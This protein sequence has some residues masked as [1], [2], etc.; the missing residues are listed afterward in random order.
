MSKNSCNSGSS[1]LSGV[2]QAVAQQELQDVSKYC[3]KHGDAYYF[4]RRAPSPFKPGQTVHL[5][6]NEDVRVG[7]NGYFR[8][9]LGTSSAAD[10]KK[11]ARKYASLLDDA[12]DRRR[13]E[14][15]YFRM[16]RGEIFVSSREATDQE[17]AKAVERMHQALLGADE[18]TSAA[19]F[20]QAIEADGD[21][22]EMAEIRD[23]DRYAELEKLLPPDTSIGRAQLVRSMARI[24][25]MVGFYLHQVVPY[26]T[27]VCSDF[28]RLI[29]FADTYIRAIKDLER[30]REGKPVEAPLSLSSAIIEEA[31]IDGD[32]A[33]D[34]AFQAYVRVR[35]PSKKTFYSYHKAWETLR[36]S[37]KCSLKQL[38]LSHVVRWRDELLSGLNG[39]GLARSTINNHITHGRTIWQTARSNA[40]IPSHL[41]NPFDGTKLLKQRN[42]Q[43][44]REEFSLDELK[45]LFSV[46]PLET[47]E[48]ISVHSG[49]WLP[50]LAMYH[51]ARLEELTGLLVADIFE[52][53][54]VPVMCIFENDRRPSL[55]NSPSQ[56][57]IPLHPKLLDL[58]FLEYVETAR[59]ANVKA[60]FPSTQVGRKFGEHYVAWA[61]R[62]LNLPE[63]RLIGMH[64]FRHGWETAR[65]N[66]LLDGSTANYLAGRRMEGNSAVDYGSPAGVLI[67]LQELSKI[68]F[69]LV[70][71][72]A[73][74]VTVQQLQEQETRA[75]RN[76]AAKVRQLGKSLADKYLS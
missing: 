35:Q 61:R 33:W 39:E 21:P 13:F 27:V 15:R 73:P 20:D 7:A 16:T 43:R 59:M 10:A 47:A 55:K 4:S 23:G 29:P 64:C 6:N 8:F 19:A 17:L 60:L 38:E 56:R 40:L 69:D 68:K 49:Y 26:E 32:S 41:G 65:R 57:T 48:A 58:G 44:S 24:N 30:R 52:L 50:I 51:G 75:I 2:A 36:Q 67:Q 11:A 46:Q 14:L 37:A 25:G 18:K 1:K 3:Y 66:G 70:F 34:D 42:A 22:E 71:Q 5:S 45:V 12:L 76:K 62:H 28:R 53:H 63:G 54:G 31:S 9:S 74:E 72:P